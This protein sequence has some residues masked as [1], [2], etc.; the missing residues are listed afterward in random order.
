MCSH[1]QV[2]SR[3]IQ[4]KMPLAKELL[5][6]FHKVV[7]SMEAME[8]SRLAIAISILVWNKLMNTMTMSGTLPFLQMVNHL[9]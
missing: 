3:S 7:P 6:I 2:D 4:L 1:R 9:K 5:V 8:S